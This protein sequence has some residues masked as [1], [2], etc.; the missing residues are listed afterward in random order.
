MEITVLIPIWCTN[1]Q[2]YTKAW[3]NT[4]NYYQPKHKCQQA[5]KPLEH[6]VIQA[7]EASNSMKNIKNLKLSPKSP[8]ANN[9]SN[10]LNYLIK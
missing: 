5:E 1:I 7:K 6:S 9:N 8:D 10:K 4:K 2:G 3:G